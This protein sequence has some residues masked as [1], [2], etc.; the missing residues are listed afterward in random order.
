MTPVLIKRMGLVPD[1]DLHALAIRM[2]RDDAKRDRG[3][4][5]QV[6][7]CDDW[8]EWRDSTMDTPDRRHWHRAQ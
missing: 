3:T 8:D 5:V 1:T 6:N 2:F 4:W 7:D